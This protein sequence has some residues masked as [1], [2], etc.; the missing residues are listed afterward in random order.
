MTM[1]ITDSELKQI[2]TLFAAGAADAEL[3]AEFRRR[4]PGLSLTRCAASDMNSEQPYRRTPGFD[5][6]L[7]D[8]ADHCWRL[9]AES[10]RATGIVLAQ[11]PL[12]TSSATA[13]GVALPP[14]SLESC[15]S[16]HS[17]VPAQRKAGA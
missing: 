6:Y 17:H 16:Q 10:A 5:L 1:A 8:R 9:T 13:P 4:F 2:E 14:P 11:R 12:P 15:L 3:A 7:V